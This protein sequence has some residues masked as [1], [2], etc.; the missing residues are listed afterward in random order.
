MKLSGPAIERFAV[1]PEAGVGGALVYGANYGL[2]QELISKMCRAL[3]GGGTQSTAQEWRASDVLADPA[4]ARDALYAGSLFGD[5]QVLW[6]RDATDKITDLLAEWLSETDDKRGFV[7][8][9][10][11]ELGPKSRLRALFENTPHLA[12]LPCYIEKG[13]DLA[14][15]ITDLLRAENITLSPAARDYLVQR[16]PADRLA[17]RGEVE[18]LSLYMGAGSTVELEAARACLGDAADADQFDL[19]WLVFDGQTMATDRALDRLFGEQTSGVAIIRALLAHALKLH[20]A[21]SLV[22]AGQ[23]KAQAIGAIKPPIFKNQQA[24]FEQHLQRWSLPRLTQAIC[25]LQDC[26]LKCKSTGYPEVALV[27]QAALLLAATA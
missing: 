9:E 10:A 1:R 18:R 17:L 11:G 7:I 24:R 22:T 20:V 5:A 16:A 23:N 4:R 8:V 2:G 6:V 12:A 27:R 25:R 26:E 14:R 19:P 21:Q 3:S 15:T 13:A